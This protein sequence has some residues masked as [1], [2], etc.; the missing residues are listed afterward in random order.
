MCSAKENICNI[1]LV[2]GHCNVPS[3]LCH[4]DKKPKTKY[5][6]TYFQRF[7]IECRAVFFFL[8]HDVLLKIKAPVSAICGIACC[9]AYVTCSMCKKRYW[10]WNCK[11]TR[12][13]RIFHMK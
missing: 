11:H 1:F 2:V 10:K 7:A 3:V 9:V 6:L 8:E 13:E 12:N 4:I 5:V